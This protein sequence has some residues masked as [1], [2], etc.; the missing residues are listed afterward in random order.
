VY[1][2]DGEEERIWTV[3][4]SAPHL[5]AGLPPEPFVDG[6]WGEHVSG[7]K[8]AVRPYAFAAPDFPPH[9]TRTRCVFCADDHRCLLQVAAVE[10][11]QH[12]WAHKPKACWMFPM[13]IVNGKPGPP[14][15]RDEPDPYD[16]GAEYPG[17]SKFVPCGQDLPD[18]LPWQAVLHD[19][20]E[21]WLKGQ[22]EW[23]D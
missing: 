15:G 23:N 7:R 19:E 13:R 12:K 4:A 8:T 18:G 6:S 3:V 1:L 16:V 9:F 2:A 17:Y 21:Y 10:Q 20:I 5:F 14:A 22:L 11:G